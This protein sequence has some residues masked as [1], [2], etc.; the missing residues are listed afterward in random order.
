MTTYGRQI[1]IKCGREKSEKDF[2]KRKNGER[3]EIC[4]TCLTMHVDNR[5]PSTFMWILEKLDIPYIER[6]WIKMA[7]EIYLKN[8]AKF[9]PM[10]V[11]GQYIRSMGMIQ[12]RDYSFKD[13]D[14]L[15]FAEQKK[16]E[17][18]ENRQQRYKENEEYFAELQK[19]LE[20]GEISEAEYNTLASD[21]KDN[22]PSRPDVPILT[23]TFIQPIEV[24]EEDIRTELEEE[25]MK[26]LALKWGT[27]YKPS[28]WVRMEELYLKYANEYELNVDRETTLR[29]I[30][31]MQLKLDQ[32]LDVGDTNAVRSLSSSLDQC[33]KSAKFTEAQNKEK[34]DKY[35]DSIGELVAF[36]EQKGGIIEQFPDDPDEYPRD[37]VDLTIKDL[38]AYTY[39][40]AV[41]ELG[42]SDLIESYIEKLEKAQAD[43]KAEVGDDLVVSADDIKAEDELADIDYYNFQNY[44]DSEIESDAK[45]MLE[46][47]GGAI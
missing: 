1:C 34:E 42:L 46:L 31:K 24:N 44:E 39:N 5:D 18:I 23:T 20:E 40:L 13:S 37:K 43:E 16:R 17:E 36:C 29:T 38:K 14:A 47:L 2:Y 10:S 45:E 21:N 6:T 28:E 22:D 11:I 26:Y 4:K 15:N 30:C 33:R 41:N 7:N 35:L 27:T 3:C 12:Y 9:G 25:D 32:A 8:P 19:K